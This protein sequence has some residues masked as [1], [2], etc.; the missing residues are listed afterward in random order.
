MWCGEEGTG[1]WSMAQ[2]EELVRAQ[3]ATQIPKALHRELRLHCVYAEIVL[4][5]FVMQALEEKLARSRGAAATDRRKHG[6]GRPLGLLWLVVA[7]AHDQNRSSRCSS[8]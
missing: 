7:D 3:L 5:D 8:P 1:G 6:A 4:M 2:T